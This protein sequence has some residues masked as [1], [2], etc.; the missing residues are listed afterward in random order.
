[1][2]VAPF[3]EL[4][5]NDVV[6]YT[7]CRRSKVKHALRHFQ[8]SNEVLADG[9]PEYLKCRCASSTAVFAAAACVGTA[10]SLPLFIL[11]VSD[12]SSDS[13]STLTISLQISSQLPP[14][15]IAHRMASKGASLRVTKDLLVKEHELML[16]IV[17]IE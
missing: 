16:I 1:M 12:I 4:C 10:A 3:L 2:R 9:V 17:E 7:E 13:L 5:G 8:S 15:G 6:S 14:F 11:P